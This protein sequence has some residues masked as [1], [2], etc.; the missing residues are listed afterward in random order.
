MKYNEL[1]PKSTS[2]SATGENTLSINLTWSTAAALNVIILSAVKSISLSAS[3]PKTKAAFKTEVI[4][5]TAPL[6]AA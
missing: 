2:L 1:V 5:V 3:L 4:P 6:V